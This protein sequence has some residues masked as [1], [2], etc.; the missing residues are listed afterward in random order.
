MIRLVAVIVVVLGG[1]LMGIKTFHA[2][3]VKKE[4]RGLVKVYAGL[5]APALDE[6]IDQAVK[7]GGENAIGPLID[8]VRDRDAALIDR[9]LAQMVLRRFREQD[10]RAR[11]ATAP[12]L[13]DATSIRLQVAIEEATLEEILGYLERGDPAWRE[14]GCRGLAMQGAKARGKADDRLLEIF[15]EDAYYPV[16]AA[17]A[18]ALG[19]LGVAKAAGPLVEA[20]KQRDGLGRASV[21]A[22]AGVPGAEARRGLEQALEIWPIA[23]AEALAERGDGAGAGALAARLGK[24]SP[25]EQMAAARALLDLGDPRGLESL[26]AALAPGPTALRV[27]ALRK[28]V[29]L[30]DA[31]VV[32]RQVAGAADLDPEIRAEAAASLGRSA[33]PLASKA[34]R[35]L[36]TDTDEVVR[37]ATLAAI[38]SR[39][40][41][42]F[43]DFLEKHVTDSDSEVA[44][45]AI[46]GS[47][48]L[49]NREI[50]PR[51]REILREGRASD[52][53]Q[54]AAWRG[55]STMT[56][57]APEL[58]ASRRGLLDVAR[59]IDLER[60]R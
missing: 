48:A 6:A 32:E 27:A 46:D 54:R 5:D 39:V 4:V 21:A 53:V 30:T 13:V 20:S 24:G 34:L 44:R 59:P 25:A 35:A 3:S 45:H 22:L 38:A 58:D 10:R 1:L 16:R 17:A 51:L 8:I 19:A 49:G 41:V 36:M 23:A 2:H 43:L 33:A 56:G 42:E 57:T 47:V 55:L 12:E 31:Q 37:R 14:A 7:Q 18:A 40:D 52:A 50:V 15:S 11:V 28:S 9:Q 26:R 60:Y 29:G